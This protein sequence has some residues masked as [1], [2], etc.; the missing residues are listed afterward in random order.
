MALDLQSGRIRWTYKVGT[1]DAWTVACFFNPPLA[2]CPNPA[3]PDWDLSGSGPNLLRNLVVF[4][5]KSGFL[6]AFDPE[7]GKLRWSTMVGPAGIFGGVE[8]GDGD[9]RQTHLRRHLE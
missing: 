8:L 2:N 3:G 4:G 7:D 6:W 5:Q 1:Y 9:G